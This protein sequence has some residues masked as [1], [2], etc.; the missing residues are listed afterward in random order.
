[1][2][3]VAETYARHVNP[4]FVKLLGVLG[5]GRVFVR[6]EGLWLWDDR[7]RR[8]LDLL[9]GFGA[10]NLGHNHPRLASRLARFFE[11]RLPNLVHTGPQPLAAELAE[12][13]AGLLPEPLEVSLFTSGGAEAVEAAMK[14][15]RAATGRPAFIHCEGAF[16]GTGLGTLPV[17]GHP[18]LRTPF[19]PLG[20][21]SAA[22]PFGD[23]AALARALEA[24][25][26]AAFLVEPIQAEGG[27]R[28]APPGYFEEAAA[29]CRRHGTLLVLDEVQTGIG[30]TGALFALPVVPDV[31][32]IAKSLGGGIA[33]IGAAVTSRELHERA[34]GTMERFDLH[35]S[36]FAGNAFACAAALETL[37]IVRE[38]GLCENAA[39]AGARLADGLRR[40]LAGHPLVRDVRGSGLLV[41]V[42]LG[43]EDR[44]RRAVTD[45]ILGQWIALKLLERGF[46]CQPAALRWDVLKIEPPLTIGSAEI[47]AA[48]AAI[49]E[50]IG[51][52]RSVAGLATGAAGRIGAQFFNGWSFR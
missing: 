21:E 29:L 10:E 8:Y 15:A 23:V 3:A 2:T 37:A 40:G 49:V 35:G 9:A 30:R 31:L 46:V 18:R 6:A 12:V 48:V 51:D 13:L 45:R 16:H 39:S 43:P 41:G 47:D 20:L 44:L 25:R 50:T 17:M 33:P 14:L 27:V 19:E 26:A 42:E 5:Y 1:M 34:Y 28:L 52:V 38:E 4:A 24:R 22:V 36:T 7:G 32:V 11:E